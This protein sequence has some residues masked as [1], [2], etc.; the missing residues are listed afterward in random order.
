MTN[1]SAGE[2]K[3]SSLFW[4]LYTL[5]WVGLAGVAVGY[6]SVVLT[7]PELVAKLMRGEAIAATRSQRRC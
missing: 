7:N 5:S 2:P 3:R 1:S 4:R 6:L